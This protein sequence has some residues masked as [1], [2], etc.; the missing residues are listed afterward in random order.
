MKK[1]IYLVQINRIYDNSVYLPYSIGCL[2]A[3]AFEDTAIADSYKLNDFIFIYEDIETAVL[4]IKDPFIVGFSTYLWNTEYNL[5]LA[6]RIKEKYPECLILFGGHNV[7]SDSAVMLEKY[8]FIDFLIHDEG[9]VPFHDL[10]VAIDNGGPL[11][12]VPNLSYRDDDGMIHSN[13]KQ[14]FDVADFPSPYLKGYF[15]SIIKNYD[16]QFQVIF[17]TNRGCPYGCAYCDWGQFKSRLRQFPIEKVLNEIKWIS[18]NKIDYCICADGNFGI[19][20]RDIEIADYLVEKKKETNYPGVICICFAKNCNDI[21]FDISKKLF[22]CG[23]IKNAMLSVQTMDETA[24]K[25]IG[26]ENLKFDKYESISDSY[27]KAGIPILSELILGLPGE[28]YDSFCEGLCR[29][30]NLG[31]H[32]SVNVY[33]CDVLLNSHMAEKKYLKNHRIKTVKMPI[34][35]LHIDYMVEDYPERSNIVVSTNTLSEEEWI[36]A[37]VFTSIVTSFHS[38]GI[39]QYFAE[40]LKYE[41]NINYKDFYTALFK[42]I[43]SVSGMKINELLLKIRDKYKSLLNGEGSWGFVLP[44]L[45]KT[46]W[47]VNET[48]FIEIIQDVEAFFNEIEPFLSSFGIDDDIYHDLLLYQKEVLKAPGLKEK[49]YSLKYDFHSYFENILNDDYK[50][51]EKKANTISVLCPDNPDSLFEYAKYNIWFG[52]RKKK[53]LCTNDM[54]VKYE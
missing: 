52:R 21:V 23:I 47:P 1:N 39:L 5:K 37:N 13:P 34:S 33:C 16:M 27:K 40:F 4:K 54:T 15:D 38:L 35:Q 17:E 24:L 2:A 25:N 10:L 11:S 12:D 41:R 48:I 28:T 3:Y 44:G 32:M 14:V 18:D 9:E 43:D 19:F 50:P 30:I 53:M 22:D 45:G 26:R 29:L 51:L 8:P 20:K 7:N 31:K 42:Y 49:S 6:E 46:I 36:N